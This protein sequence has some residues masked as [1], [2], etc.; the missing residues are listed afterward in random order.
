MSGLLGI[1]LALM[2]GV[3]PRVAAVTGTLLYVMM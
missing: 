3:G 1:G 2:L